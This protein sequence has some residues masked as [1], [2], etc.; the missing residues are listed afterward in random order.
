MAEFKGR[1][2]EAADHSQQRLDAALERVHQLEEELNRQSF[3]VSKAEVGQFI[4]T[5]PTFLVSK[6]GVS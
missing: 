4:A 3:L 6:R 5:S 1:L 2:Q